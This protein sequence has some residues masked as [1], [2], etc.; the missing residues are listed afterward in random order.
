MKPISLLLSLS[1]GALAASAQILPASPAPANSPVHLEEF[2]VTGSPLGRAPDEVAQ[3]NSV[4]AGERLLLLRQAT[5]GETLAT[6]PGISSSYFGPGASRPIIRGLGADRVRVLTGGIGTLDASVISPDHAVS[7]DPLLIE[8]IEIVRGPATLLYGG[9]AVG[10]VVNVI[11]ERI[12]EEFPATPF[13]GRVETRFGSAAE[14]RAAAGVLTG[15]SGPLVWR[16][17]GFTRQT[18]DVRI[19]DFA[20]TAARRA[21]RDPVIDGPPPRDR[22][23]NSAAKTSGAGA[24]ISY[25]SAHGHL[26]IGYSGF[27]SRYGVPGDEAEPVDI[28]LR[29]RRWDLH[30]ELLEPTTWLRGAKL[31]FGVGDYRHVELEGDEVGTRFTNRAHEGRLELRHAKLADL[32]GA[33]GFQSSR[34]NFAAAGDEAF[35]PPSVTSNHAVFLYEELPVGAVTWQFGTR[36]ERQKITPDAP[37]LGARSHTGA[38]FSGGAVWKLDDTYS[39]AFSAAHSERAPNAQE[40]FAHGPHAGTGV[41][42][43]GDDR[44]GVERS[45]GFDLSLRKRTGLITGSAT[46]FTNRFSGYI[47]ENDT[48]ALD[49]D[50]GLPIYQFVQHD[51]D[52]TGAELELVAH[53]HEAAG[54]QLDLRLTGDYVRAQNR[55][56]AQPLPRTTPARIGAAVDFRT[57]RFTFTA[58]L[59]QTRRAERLAS[60]ETATDGHALVNVFAAWRFKLG[61]A[62]AELFGRASN[63][64]NATARAHTSFLKDIAPLPGRDFTAGLRLAF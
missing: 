9:S 63:L 14:E 53:L 5:L 33:L 29:Q 48:G 42:E 61:R 12:P 36:A 10:G 26:G 43:V 46:L 55:S 62:D 32:E 6:Q 56:T 20:E 27:D 31:Q 4:V 39:L 34:S 8:R 28:D 11:D 3:P 57:A 41:F 25:L 51:A 54:T 64:G 45:A 60:N 35:L 49:V 52:F 24:G 44:L 47:F 30:G 19:P 16:V 50:S 2:V 58:E 38:S 7:L 17:D 1:A 37:G 22:L 21:A 23:P 13:G 59:R 40:L 15:R 18:D